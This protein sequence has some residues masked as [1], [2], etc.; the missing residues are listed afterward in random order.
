MIWHSSQI[1]EVLQELYVDSE[2]GLANGVADQRLEIFGTNTVSTT[3]DSSFIQKVLKQLNNKMVY[4]LTA[5]A[6]ISFIISLIYEKSDVFSP[7]LILAIVLINALISAFHL[8]KSDMALDSLNTYNNPDATV[9]RDGIEKKIPSSELV[10]GDIIIL[11]EG[12]YICA[13]SRII[14]SNGL[15]CNE[16]PLTGDIIPVDKRADITVE[17]IAPIDKRINMLFTGCSVIHGSC[18]AVVVETGINTEIGKTSTIIKQTGSDRLPVQNILDVT[19]NIMNVVVFIAAAIAF[20]IGMIQNFTSS[21]PF[22]RTTML[23]LLNSLCLAIATIPESIPTIAKVV[24]AL[25]IKRI[26]NDDIFV[27]KVSAVETL[28]KTTI[29]CAN[30]T[31]VLTKNHMQLD[32][33]FNGDAVVD[34]LSEDSLDDKTATALKLA[35]ACSMLNNDYTERAI[36]ESCIQ[37]C[38]MSKTD[39]ENSLPRLATIPFDKYRKTMT[40]INMING[41]PVAIVKGAAENVVEK[42]HSIDPSLILKVSEEMAEKEYRVLCIAIKSLDEIPANPNPDEIENDLTF[43]ALLGLI[44]PPRTEAIDEIKACEAAGIKTIMMTGD[45]L[46]TAK[47]IARRI[48]ILKNDTLAITGEELEAFTDEELAEKIQNFTVFAR[49]SPQDKIRIVKAFQDCG[50]IVAVTG[51]SVEDADALS[52]ANIGCAV[53]KNGTDIAK[54]NAD[55]IISNNNFSLVVNAI[56]ESRGLFANIKKA[57]TYLLS[58]N[59]AE[60]ITYI[61]GMLI[62]RIPPISAIQLLWVNLLTDCAPAISL[63]METADSEVMHKKPNTL[64]GRLFDSK[65]LIAISAEALFMAATALIAFLIGFS[66]S[67]SVAMTLTFFV[68]SVSQI[69]HSYNKKTDKSIV[70]ISFKTNRF[71]LFSTILTLFITLFLCLT[72][73]GFVFGLSMLSINQLFIGLG[74]SFA[75]IPFCEILK[76]LIRLK[77]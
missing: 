54:G 7:I 3:K 76:V 15:R 40:S 18:K 21:E 51:D 50:E 42:C 60:I 23:M 55:I 56:K 74:L 22:A 68:L 52:I 58:C 53:G 70:G 57:V 30:K 62:F 41:R 37:H 44:D 16:S 2:K 47:S 35:T 6:I 61:L 14:E 17:D 46:I 69:F 39:I 4:V 34:L 48:G 71:M 77:K 27:K 10:P 19:S 9:L 59:F 25:G 36:E 32:C 31:G 67:V 63:T 8:H 1:D 13:D 64:S 29:I 28:G 75:I 33:V 65:S 12:D 26:L 45:N 73:A 24:M 38:S 5:V 11:N 49:I 72:P 20:I 66:T 43:V